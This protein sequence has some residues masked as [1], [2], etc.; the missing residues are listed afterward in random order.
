MNI[1]LR[2]IALIEKQMEEQE[3]EIKTLGYCSTPFDQEF[4]RKISYLMDK[5]RD[6]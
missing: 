2:K 1:A 3:E 5:V 4:K 6:I